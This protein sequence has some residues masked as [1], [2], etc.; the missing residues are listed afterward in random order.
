MEKNYAQSY[1][2]L[3]CNHW[4]WRA[5]EK[6]ILAEIKRLGFSADGS[7][8]F[9]DVGC[10]DGLLFDALEPFGEIH[11]VEADAETFTGDGKWQDNIYHQRFDQTFQPNRQFDLI[12]MLDLL[13]HLADPQAALEHAKSLLKPNGKLLMT[14]PAF[15][16]L[17]TTHDDLNHHH[18]RYTRPTFSTLAKHAGIRLHKLRYLYHWTCPLKL[19]IRMKE[20]LMQSKAAPPAVPFGILNLAC[21]AL[22]RFEQM[23]ISR[24][25]MPFG[26]SLLAVGSREG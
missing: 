12:L 13:E 2:D 18:V 16:S 17:W 26:S 24:I 6:A 25:G 10:G 8:S 22:S 3:Y 4:W 20:K 23:T 7:H 14:V 15:Q 1:R 5:R 11:G 21:F 19:A 9:L